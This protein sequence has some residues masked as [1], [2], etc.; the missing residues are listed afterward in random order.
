MFDCIELMIQMH[1]DISDSIHGISNHET[2]S[3]M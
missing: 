1:G 3:V 2:C